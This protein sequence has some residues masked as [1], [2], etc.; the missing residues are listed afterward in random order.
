MGGSQ[1]ENDPIELEE[2][3]H[4]ID[5]MKSMECIDHEVKYLAVIL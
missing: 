5:S 1:D 3:Y 4:D 2:K